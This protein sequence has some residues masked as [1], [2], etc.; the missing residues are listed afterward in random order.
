MLDLLMMITLAAAFAGAFGYV[1]ACEDMT[2][3][4]RPSSEPGP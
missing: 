2:N 4:R 1:W 3:R